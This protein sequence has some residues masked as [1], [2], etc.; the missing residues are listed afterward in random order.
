MDQSIRAV[1][2]AKDR[3][4]DISAKQWLLQEVLHA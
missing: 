4:S 1:R 2:R 3:P